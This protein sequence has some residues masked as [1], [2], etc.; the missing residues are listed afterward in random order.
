MR[1]EADRHRK[2]VAEAE[3]QRAE[4]QVRIVN[5]DK[6]ALLQVAGIYAY[7]P[8]PHDAIAYRSRFD[9]RQNE[10]K[11]PARAGIS[12]VSPPLSPAVDSGRVR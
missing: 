10:V 1:N 3:L 9:Q 8:A 11:A 4:S 7:R 6:T 2:D 5:A 12:A